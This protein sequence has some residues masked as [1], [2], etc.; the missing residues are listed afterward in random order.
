LNSKPFAKTNTFKAK[1]ED[2]AY[3]TVKTFPECECVIWM[4]VIETDFGQE[5]FF[6]ADPNDIIRSGNFNRVPVMIGRT[7]DE[8]ASFVPSLLGSSRLDFFNENFNQMAPYC[9]FY[10][11][12]EQ[13]KSDELSQALKKAFLP[14]KKIDV[15]SFNGLN[16]LFGDGIIGYPVH[17]FVQLASRFTDVYYY[18]F[19]FI[20]R[21]GWEYP[22]DKPFGVNHGDDLKYSFDVGVNISKSDPE[23]FMVVRMTKIIDVFARTG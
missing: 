23:N 2:I 12:M 5:R 15:R 6:T 19:S 1:P 16:H 3:Q 17:R 4:P 9:F 20:G 11:P 8:F 14:Y 10:H 13:K 7:T 22:D 18:K 21:Y